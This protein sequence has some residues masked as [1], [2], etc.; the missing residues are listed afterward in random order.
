[1]HSPGPAAADGATGGDAEHLEFKV[2]LVGDVGVGKTC[3]A[4]RASLGH[5]DGG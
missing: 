2:A 1:M 4:R 3:L 5:F